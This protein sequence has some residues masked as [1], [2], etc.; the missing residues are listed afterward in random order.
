MDFLAEFEVGAPASDALNELF[1][2]RE[3]L[4]RVI[5]RPVDVLMLAAECN[6]FAKA[7][8]ESNRR[9]FYAA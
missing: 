3:G 9:L 8:L 2:L 7:D 1:E 4:A 6:P 5:G